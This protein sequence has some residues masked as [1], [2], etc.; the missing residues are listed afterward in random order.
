MLYY[1]HVNE[2]NSVE[3][4]L[5]QRSDSK[6]AIAV[7]GSGERV[8]ALMDHPS[9][10]RVVAI[11]IN[12]QALFLLQLKLEALKALTVEEYL[13]FI[14][15][16]QCKRGDRGE[17]FKRIA[18]YLTHDCS[19]Y[20]RDRMNRVEAGLL[21]TGHFE[22]FLSGIRPLLVSFLGR[23]FLRILCDATYTLDAG[24]RMRWRLIAGTFSRKWIYRLMGN[25]DV[26][27]IGDGADVRIIPDALTSMID[28]RRA[29]ASFLLH[30]IFK[31]H[32]RDMSSPAL[33]PSLQEA[34]LGKIKERLTRKKVSVEFCH[35]DV[36]EYAKH[37]PCDLPAF[38]S[39]SDILSFEDHDYLAE[40]LE[41]IPDRKGTVIV[42]R[43]FLRNRLSLVQLKELVRS[44]RE[45][46]FL[47]EFDRSGMYQVI[48][49]ER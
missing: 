11:D 16:A 17:L 2:D 31:G 18:P 1:A 21:G 24:Q 26:A 36:L 41:T 20:W 34:V 10:E 8:L 6:I 38:Y 32:L 49:I 35:A 7:A 46:R 42:V 43:S 45:I 27:F 30:L 22:L 44:Y 12:P 37:H 5:L 25:R 47:D 9:L 14:G 39:L 13:R 28:G 15:H 23:R 33:P 3:R 4:T 29:S 48:V 19:V 40:L